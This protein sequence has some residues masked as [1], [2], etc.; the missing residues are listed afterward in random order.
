M[1]FLAAVAPQYRREDDDRRI[2]AESVKEAER[3]EIDPPLVVDRR[4]PGDRPGRHDADQGPV[5]RHDVRRLYIDDHSIDPAQGISRVVQFDGLTC[6]LQGP[7]GIDHDGQ[8]VGGADLSAG[9]DRAGMRSMGYTAG[10]K[11]KRGL[12]TP[13]RLPK[14]PRT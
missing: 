2:G 5:D 10:M 8:L 4:D 9:D 12:S 7:E 14:W 3:G 6:Q 1:S 13:R 11:R